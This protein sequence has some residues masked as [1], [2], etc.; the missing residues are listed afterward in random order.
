MVL[1]KDHVTIRV[2][3]CN[4]V[5]GYYICKKFLLKVL[6]SPFAVVLDGRFPVLMSDLYSAKVPLEGE[7]LFVKSF[8]RVHQVK[9]TLNENEFAL[10]NKLV[11]EKKSDRASVFREL[12]NTYLASNKNPDQYI[13]PD[14]VSDSQKRFESIPLKYLEDLKEAFDKSLISEE[15]YKMLREISLGLKKS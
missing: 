9:V 4:I 8:K 15:E 3:R 12:L 1:V 10:L 5:S 2:L 11:Q 7:E 13:S 6:L 14:L